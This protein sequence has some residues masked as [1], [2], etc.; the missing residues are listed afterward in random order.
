MLQFI[1]ERGGRK[2]DFMHG[3]MLHIDLQ[4]ISSHFACFL[5]G[6]TL[7]CAQHIKGLYYEEMSQLTLFLLGNYLFSNG[8]LDMDIEFIVPAFALGQARYR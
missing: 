1:A 6:L 5:K 7:S 8:L 3:T 2:R 4:P